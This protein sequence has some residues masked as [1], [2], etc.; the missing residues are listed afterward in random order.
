MN[1]II[2]PPALQKGDTIGIIAPCS[3]YD[4]PLLKEAE[5]LFTSR[6]YKIFYHDQIHKR[7]GQFAGTSNERAAA[8]NEV[9]ANP[10]VKAVMPIAAG[11]GAIHILDK[12]DYNLIKENPKIFIGFSDVTTLL[13][14]INTKTGLVTFHG[15]TF[16]RSVRISQKWQDHLFGVLEGRVDS[17]DLDTDHILQG[18]LLGGC[19]STLQ[20]LIGTPYEPDTSNAL[21]FLED[22]NDHLSRYD[23][24]LGHMR[25]AGWLKDLQAILLGDFLETK[26]SEDRPFGFTIE[27]SVKM[28]L[29]EKTPIIS[30]FPVGHGDDLATLPIG[31]NAALKNGA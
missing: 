11:N 18:K 14:A 28:V 8:L 27:E 21:L 3:H 30:K 31:A 16:A 25:Q 17:L 6:G 24:M 29:P 9:F 13:H 22:L 20:S 5:E 23:R 19:L 26:D 12:I 2:Y 15:P 7:H 4:A 1:Q 10:D